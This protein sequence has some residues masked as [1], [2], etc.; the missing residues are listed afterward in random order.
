VLEN[1][2]ANWPYFVLMGVAGG[3]L[4]GMFGIG[5]GLI[6]VPMLLWLTTASQKEAQGLSLGFIIFTALA[7]FLSYK[8]T[9]SIKMDYRVVALL[10][11]GGIA[12][13]F[14]G[15]Y[16]MN[17]MPTLWLSRLFA[18]LMIL[19]AVKL[20][21]QPPSDKAAAQ[22]GN[23]VTSISQPEGSGGNSQ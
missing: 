13:A 4:S 17:H 18:C 7:A 1:L 6:M 22:P 11:V 15:A 19:A 20:L 3:F 16:A 23:A 9:F 5:G 2:V 10:G 8:Y 14:L 12:G 21:V